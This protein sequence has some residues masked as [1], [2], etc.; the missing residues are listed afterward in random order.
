MN[1]RLVVSTFA[2]VASVLATSSAFAA[3]L[4]IHTPMHAAFTA[5][6]PNVQIVKINLRNDSA[7]PITLNAG[8]TQVTLAPG[9][10]TA[11]R[12]AVGTRLTAKGTSTQYTAGTLIAVVDAHLN[13][14]TL[15]LK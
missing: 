8:D 13:H 5:S 15:S 3:P 4:A 2:L 11:V 7:E 14:A 6:T 1:R 9:K 12:V 10:V